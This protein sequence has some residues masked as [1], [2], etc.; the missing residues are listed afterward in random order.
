MD[1]G[2]LETAEVRLGVT[3]VLL[4]CRDLLFLSPSHVGQ[5]YTTSSLAVSEFRN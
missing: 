1:C 3:G 4:Y 5:N 2:D